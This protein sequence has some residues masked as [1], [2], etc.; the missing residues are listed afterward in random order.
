MGGG[1]E[2]IMEV[3]SKL[4]KFFRLRV[5]VPWEGGR[6]ANRGYVGLSVRNIKLVWFMGMGE[7]SLPLFWLMLSG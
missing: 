7:I 3:L 4:E 5:T 2:A 6:G 1:V